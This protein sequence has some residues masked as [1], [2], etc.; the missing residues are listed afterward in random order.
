MQE[1]RTSNY[2]CSKLILLMKEKEKKNIV[3]KN[4]LK[5]LV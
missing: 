2:L 1:H 4:A 5:E 3:L